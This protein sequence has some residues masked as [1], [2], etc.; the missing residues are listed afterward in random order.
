MPGFALIRI[1][2]GIYFL[3]VQ[4]G[5]AGLLR[6]PTSCSAATGTWHYQAVQLVPGRA[7][8]IVP[9]TQGGVGKIQCVFT[10]HSCF[11]KTAFSEKDT[12]SELISSPLLL[13]CSHCPQAAELLSEPP[14]G[15]DRTGD[16]GAVAA[17]TQRNCP[18][19]LA[20]LLGSRTPAF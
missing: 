20:S 17:L 15:R 14:G 7:P 13:L 18:A 9:G 5:L 11:H 4:L 19:L 8:G 16:G 10:N 2:E 3:A 6:Q 12:F 1:T